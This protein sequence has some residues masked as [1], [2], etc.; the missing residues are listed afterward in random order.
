MPDELETH[1]VIDMLDQFAECGVV[2]LAISGGEPLLR[3]DLFRVIDHAKQLGL[4]VGVGSNGGKLSRQQARSLSS[5]DLDRFQVS[6]DGVGAEHDRL[7]CWPGL[8]ERALHTIALAQNEGLRVHVCFTITR[9]NVNEIEDMAALVKAHGVRR[10]NLSRFVAT[11]RGV[12]SLELPD[13][14]W[15]GVIRRCQALR[16]RLAPELEVVT[17][18][19]QQVLIDD[20]AACMPAFIGCQA[21]VAQGCVQADG[22]VFPCVLLP[23]AIGNIRKQRFSELWENSPTIR[24]LRDRSLLKG[25][26]GTCDHRARCGGCRAVAFARTGDLLAPDP[27][28]WLAGHPPSQPRT[29]LP[30]VPDQ[31]LRSGGQP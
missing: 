14:A 1:E 17:H 18:L 3:H 6:L 8:F 21:G 31:C 28:C 9:F 19:A 24:T 27:R 13:A 30:V 10:L 23:I 20:E 4:S 22:T 2:D 26:C 16:Q 15:Q 11:G 29:V 5:L 7:R 12:A 25:R